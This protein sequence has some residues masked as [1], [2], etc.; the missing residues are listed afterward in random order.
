MILDTKCGPS[1]AV[2]WAVSA[3]SSLVNQN[4]YSPNQLVFGQNFKLPSVVVNKLPA[5]ENTCASEKVQLHL[6]ALHKAREGF[7]EAESDSRIK[8]ALRH[9][10]RSY[11]AVPVK[12]GDQVF[13]KNKYSP[14]WRGPGKVLGLDGSLVLVRHGGL[15]L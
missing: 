15:F 5:L 12:Q 3:K 11:S 2:A 4:G 8:R 1:V 9:K 13:F 10:T 14:K 7:I 6:Q